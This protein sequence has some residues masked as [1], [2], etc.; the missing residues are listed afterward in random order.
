MYLR[1]QSHGPEIS[2]G[3]PGNLLLVGKNLFSPVCW[4]VAAGCTQV[5]SVIKRVPHLLVFASI[6]SRLLWL[7]LV[8]KTITRAK[9]VMKKPETDITCLQCE[10]YALVLKP[11][12]FKRRRNNKQ[13]LANW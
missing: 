6:A 2:Q 11:T 7:Q 8:W 13:P 1:S 9:S 12:S 4:Q 10:S 5:K 3:P